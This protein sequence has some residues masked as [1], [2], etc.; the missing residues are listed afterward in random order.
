MVD[1]SKQQMENDARE[2]VERMRKQFELKAQEEAM[3]RESF[4]KQQAIQEAELQATLDHLR[5]QFSVMGTQL[6]FY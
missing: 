4:I 3:K 6:I 2:S 5:E 1:Q